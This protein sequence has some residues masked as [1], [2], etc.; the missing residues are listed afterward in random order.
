[1]V[2]MLM[3]YQWARQQYKKKINVSKGFKRS[4]IVGLCHDKNI[5]DLKCVY[6]H[7][8]VQTI[9]RNISWVICVYI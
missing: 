2:V 7:I 8:Y 3:E 9:K 6:Q 4:W 5:D 1:M